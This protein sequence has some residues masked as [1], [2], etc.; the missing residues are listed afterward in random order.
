MTLIKAKRLMLF[1]VENLPTQSR[2]KTTGNAIHAVT[3]ALEMC[4]N[5]A[6]AW[7]RKRTCNF[8]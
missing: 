5:L 8:S 2:R 7:E 1:Q 6:M 4:V 3:A